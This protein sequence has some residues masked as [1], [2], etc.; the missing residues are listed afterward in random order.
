MSPADP[1][2]GFELFEGSAP[3]RWFYRWA[4]TAAIVASP[5]RRALLLAAVCW[6]PLALLS[7][8]SGLATGGVDLPFLADFEV[9]ARF[10]LALPLL[11]LAERFA[12]RIIGPGIFQNPFR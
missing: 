2:D 4:P 1:T 7:S 11:I 5:H 3:G 12:H 9:H 10:L 6:L 8:A